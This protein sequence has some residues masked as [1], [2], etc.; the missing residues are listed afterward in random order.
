M[1]AA[2][3]RLLRGLGALVLLV[4]VLAGLPWVL[5]RIG[6]Q[7]IP[8]HIPSWTEVQVALISNDAS[9]VLLVLL[10]A[11]GWIAWVVFCV[12]TVLE[13]VAVAS[14]QRIHIRL[15]GLGT[16]TQRVAAAL[17]VAVVLAVLP[18]GPPT[19]AGPAAPP[20]PAVSYSQT[21][22]ASPAGTP[23]T[24]TTTPATTPATPPPARSAPAAGGSV[25][26]RAAQ[27]MTPV[28]AHPA[29]AG[30]AAGR[31]VIHHTVRHNDTLWDLA[32]R[33]YGSG[34]QWQTIAAENHLRHGSVLEVGQRLQ[35]TVEHASRSADE[36]TVHRGDTLSGIAADQLGDATA[37][38]QI[39]Q[40]NRAEIADPDLIYPGEHL[41]IPGGTA[42]GPAG[43][44]A[45]AAITDN[46]N[47]QP[48]GTTRTPEPAQP[49]TTPS[50]P[51]QQAAPPDTTTSA[52][53]TSA[54]SA[55]SATAAPSATG[56]PAATKPAVGQNG[57]A[58]QPG[59]EAVSTDRLVE[60]AIAFAG[61]GGLL[62]V[63]LVLTL[64][65]RR[66]RQLRSRPTGRSIPEPP[67]EAQIVETA[68]SSQPHSLVHQSLGQILRAISA[69]TYTGAG[70]LPQVYA[71][72]VA[73]NRLDLRLTAPHLDPPAGIR[74]SRDG[75]AWTVTADQVGTVLA[76]DGLQDAAQ[77][78]PA[79]VTVGRD[80]DDAL[81][82]LNLERAGMLT[83]TT[84]SPRVSRQ[85]V[86]ALTMEMAVSPWNADL[87]LILVGEVCPGLETALGVPTVIR[88]EDADEAAEVVD[89][90]ATE[91]RVHLDLE[92]STPAASVTATSGVGQKR[93][94]P[95][96]AESWA[97]TLIVFGELPTPA[98]QHRL[99]RAA[100][101]LPRV[102]VAVVSAAEVDDDTS[103][104]GD[105]GVDDGA[106][107]AC[108]MT[109]SA[110]GSQAGLDPY[111]W[112]L[113]PQLIDDDIYREALILLEVTGRT[114]TTPATW[115]DGADTADS[116]ATDVDGA[117]AVEAAFVDEVTG[118]AAPGDDPTGAAEAHSRPAAEAG[119]D[120][121]D[122]AVDG[123]TDGEGGEVGQDGDP[124]GNVPS[125]AAE[126]TAVLRGGPSPLLPAGSTL[127]DRLGAGPGIAPARGPGVQ[128]NRKIE[129]AGPAGTDAGDD[130]GEPEED[131]PAG[132][133]RP[134][135]RPAAAMASVHHIPRPIMPQ[136]GVPFLQILGPVGLV[137][138]GGE[139]GRATRRSLEML[140]ILIEK[141]GATVSTLAG[142][143]VT[144]QATVRTT[145]TH[146][147]GWLG[148]TDDG[149]QFLPSGYAGYRL[150]ERV[151]SDWHEL[152]WC[153][154]GGIH[155]ASDAKLAEALAWVGG[156]PF[157]GA[158][159]H[160]WSF[161][162]F[163]SQVQS[164]LVELVREII[165]RAL[166]RNDVAAARK[167]VAIGLQVD[168]SSELL[169]ADAVR[170][171]IA[172][173][174]PAGAD[175]IRRQIYHQADEIG[176]DL[177][178]ETVHIL[179]AAGL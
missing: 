162:I 171:E 73:E 30:H 15:P 174:N 156:T 19:K 134:Q 157:E 168:Q 61:A 37:W 165:R 16:T 12:S 20:T 72:R 116:H 91:Q 44:N 23:A 122:A 121:T 51:S 108:R 175:R 126:E 8:D 173:G 142:T 82:L 131:Q 24:P 55:P 69:H 170:T 77:P 123:A 97:P 60:L 80:A 169:L 125:R 85:A 95:D 124:A 42:A 143:F 14:R 144:S 71:A 113:Q 133:G 88:A 158:A 27:V 31:S 137:G 98:A 138:A 161:G 3:A 36:V 52:P 9:H 21:H 4:A 146:L 1:T 45:R 26:Q 99:A 2:V 67:A 102:A 87:R 103:A 164:T 40:A 50:A 83:I 78:W 149:G 66:A 57:Q 11:A 129:D 159:D 62:A 34:E 49:T 43:G 59:A 47:D 105:L 92:S 86:T 139:R 148:R 114:D 167:A 79:L 93:V 29:E 18:H 46:N 163:R 33:Y 130:V 179:A 101:A 109:I 147:R 41:T 7:V 13:L 172:G 141:P 75:L 115:W 56:R 140:H 153:I 89:A 25:Q 150:D 22:H 120:T 68:I 81:V 177:I 166:D 151:S 100:L 70:D 10:T 119:P 107:P 63:G 17:I 65:R 84:D 64:R 110:D 38:P 154:R 28:V 132:T 135:R 94:D 160:E 127:L 118:E 6:V 54:T 53:S 32:H 176:C 58:V 145:I 155:H 128:E 76:A 48:G 96:L 5:R 104:L 74:A 90:L 178:D 112:T 152:S 117:A 106:E 136:P 35:I 39:Y 111:G